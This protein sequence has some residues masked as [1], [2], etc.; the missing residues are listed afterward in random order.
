MSHSIA[1][2]LATTDIFDRLTETQ[3]ELIVSISATQAYDA[4]QILF[5]E[6][7]LS[8]ELYVIL[9]GVIEILVDPGLVGVEGTTEPVVLAELRAGQVVG[10]MALVDQGARSATAR[11]RSKGTQ[12]LRVPRKRLMLL[13]DTY[14][15]LGYKLMRNLAADL[16]LKIRNTDL[17]VRQYQLLLHRRGQ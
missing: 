8:D 7:E 2:I 9:R 6:N 12:L 15:E 3:L 14:P 17:T 11:V 5:E 4:G 10:E 16:A 1:S 13:C